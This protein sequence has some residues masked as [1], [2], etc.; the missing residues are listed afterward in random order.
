[1][2]IADLS[3]AVADETG[4]AGEQQRRIVS[5]VFNQIVLAVGRGDE[6][7]ITGFGKFTARE[8]AARKG[9]NPATGE[10]IE[11]RA[12]TKVAFS[13]AKALKRW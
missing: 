7:S 13:P 3:K 1:M 12:S 8:L 4:I 11:I 10:T 9:R 6:V 2:N 5:S